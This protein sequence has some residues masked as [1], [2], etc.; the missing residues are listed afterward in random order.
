M[1]EQAPIAFRPESIAASCGVSRSR[2]YQAIAAG[3]L[4]ARRLGTRLVV[5]RRD[6]EQWL[7]NLPDGKKEQ[8]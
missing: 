3:D 5:L 1:D 2:I 4:P 7:S 6:A 8:E